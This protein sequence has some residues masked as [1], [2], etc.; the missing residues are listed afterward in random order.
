MHPG[1]ATEW[2]N[3]IAPCIIGLDKV[4]T[5]MQLGVLLYLLI[6]WCFTTLCEQAASWV[7]FLVKKHFLRIVERVRLRVS[8]FIIVLGV[9][10]PPP[11]QCSNRNYARRSPSPDDWKSNLFLFERVYAIWCKTDRPHTNTEPK[12]HRQKKYDDTPS[13]GDVIPG[14]PPPW[15]SSP[16]PPASPPEFLRGR[17]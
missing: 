6:L 5:K 8:C 16:S 7:V 9:P 13:Q 4:Q 14:P 15:M 11:S 3:S 10:G 17:D 2:L 12:C 1:P